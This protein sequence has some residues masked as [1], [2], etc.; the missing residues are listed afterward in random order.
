MLYLD[1]NPQ[2]LKKQRVYNVAEGLLTGKLGG[3]CYAIVAFVVLSTDQ[4]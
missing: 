3:V 1:R 2:I 4:V